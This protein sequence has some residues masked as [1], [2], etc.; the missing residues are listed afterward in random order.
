MTNIYNKPVVLDDRCN[1]LITFTDYKKLSQDERTI[2]LYDQ[3]SKRIV[4]KIICKFNNKDYYYY[5]RM[6]GLIN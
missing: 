1:L 4:I 6:K 2:R 3:D 5:C